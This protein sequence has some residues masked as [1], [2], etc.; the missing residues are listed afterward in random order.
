MEEEVS[1]HLVTIPLTLIACAII[2]VRVNLETVQIFSE[3]GEEFRLWGYVAGTNKIRFGLHHPNPKTNYNATFTVAIIKSAKGN[4]H[5]LRF[6]DDCAEIERGQLSSTWIT[7]TVQVK[8]ITRMVE[9]ANHHDLE[10]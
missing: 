6:T 2:A 10:V 7:D 3:G 9:K 1:T 5:F 4:K 8:C